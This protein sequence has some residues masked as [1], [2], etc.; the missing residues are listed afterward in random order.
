LRRAV[1]R[2]L[3]D[4]SIVAYSEIPTTT[5]INAISM[6]RFADVFDDS[7]GEAEAFPGMGTAPDPAAPAN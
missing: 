7:P 4:L 2:S 5:L 1:Y 3:P 6:V